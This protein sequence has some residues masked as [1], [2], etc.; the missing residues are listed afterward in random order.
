[1][2]VHDWTQVDAGVFHDFHLAW[3]AR[4]K[5]ALNEEILPRPYYAL[6]E[7]LLG[8]I[9]PD[10]IA[11]EA[12]PRSGEVPI[13]PPREE[14][15]RLHHDAT[16]GA[17]ALAPGEILVEEFQPDPYARKARQIT[18]KNAWDGD[19]V[20]A[21]I[22][23]VSGGN[24]SSRARAE[25][26]LDKSVGLLETG[27][28]LVLVDLHPGTRIVPDGFHAL[29]SEQLG[30]EPSPPPAERP[31]SAVSYQVLEMGA[32]RA[33]LVPLRVG[34]RL[35]DLAVFLGPHEFVRLP[36]EATCEES[37]RTVPWKYQEIL[38]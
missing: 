11:V 21:V 25:Q 15:P 20:V 3:I 36:L 31:L 34:D 6:A 24:K 29:I 14:E 8:D 10:V 16:E 26:F 38:A 13:E 27:I 33:H 22:E 4:L 37:F 9:G 32:L 23:V 12:A 28:H 17:V 19:R 5:G 2:P 1:M 18:I 30:H 7:P 35:P